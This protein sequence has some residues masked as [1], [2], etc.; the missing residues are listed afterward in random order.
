MSFPSYVEKETQE[1][2]IHNSKSTAI[3]FLQIFLFSLSRSVIGWIRK[4]TRPSTTPDCFL[5]RF[6]ARIF[7]EEIFRCCLPLYIRTISERWL[8]A[9]RYACMR[10]HRGIH[11]RAC[12][13]FRRSAVISNISWVSLW[14]N[15]VKEE[16]EREDRRETEVK[17]GG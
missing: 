13:H 15:T 6:N 12:S 3:F 8:Y 1:L 11:E 17:K 14:H 5:L 4:R 2:N 7:V 16:D 10:I 9:P